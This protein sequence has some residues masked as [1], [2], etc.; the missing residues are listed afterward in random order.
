MPIQQ[1]SATD[2]EISHIT[3]KYHG[4]FKINEYQLRHQLFNGGY[5]KTL[6]REVFERGDA[7][8]LMPYD[9]TNDSLVFITQFRVGAVN[10]DKNTLQSPWLLEFVAGMFAENEA[11]I[12][13]AIRE[14]KEEAN[15]TL[16][17]ENITPI[18]QYFSSP[19]GMS[20][21]IHLYVGY[22]DSTDIE[23]NNLSGVYGLE[24]EGEDIL[25]SVISRIEAMALLA[26]GKINNA[27]T[28]I[29][30]QWLQLNYQQLQKKY[31]SKEK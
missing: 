4:F 6:S 21:K 14:A 30:L 2:V 20:E 28:V 3:T 15:L 9:I 22:V 24:H 5:S 27:A 17:A 13:V 16:Q 11:P 10:K 23:G 19:G 12:D 18:M 25:V 31:R 8:V 26:Q 7:V 29:G 1:F